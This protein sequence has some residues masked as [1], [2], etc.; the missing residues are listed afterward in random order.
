M[1]GGRELCDQEQPEPPGEISTP[2]LNESTPVIRQSIRRGIREKKDRSRPLYV[3]KKKLWVEPE[4]TPD[5]E[6]NKQL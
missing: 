1:R 3:A 6:E 4:R 5:E 2:P